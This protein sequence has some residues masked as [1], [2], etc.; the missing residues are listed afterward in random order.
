MQCITSIYYQACSISFEAQLPLTRCDLCC[1]LRLQ[2]TPFFR[3]VIITMATTHSISSQRCPTLS[4]PSST[5]LAASPIRYP[6]PHPMSINCL[7]NEI[8]QTSNWLANC[9]EILN[10]F[11]LRC[12]L[13]FTSCT[14]LQLTGQTDH[15][16]QS[17]THHAYINHVNPH[18]WKAD[19][20]NACLLFV[21]F[22]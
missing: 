18:W 4:L 13:L 19:E 16:Q 1:R 14:F 7:A 8:N 17:C 9:C 20:Y 6:A 10:C 11:T 22:W 5:L 21:D 12:S 3:S 15:M 2:T